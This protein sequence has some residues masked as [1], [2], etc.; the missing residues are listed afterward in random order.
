MHIESSLSS[1]GRSGEK[2]GH[3]RVSAESP[4]MRVL[5]VDD[6]AMFRREATRLCELEG[7]QTTTAGSFDELH[8]ALEGPRPDIVLMDVDLPTIPG[9]RLGTL[10][11][12]RF[13][14]PICLVSALPED[15]LRRMFESSDADAWISKPLTRDKLVG[16]VSKLVDRAKLKESMVERVRP[17]KGEA[18]ILLVED[19]HI[20]TDRIEHVLGPFGT[21]TTVIDG[22]GAISHLFDG[23]F[24][25]IVL[26][27][28]LPR[29][30]GFDVIR[31]LMMHRPDLLGATIVITGAQESSL[32]FIDASVLKAVLIK[33]FDFLELPRLVGEL[34]E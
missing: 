32:Q 27:L 6:N 16:V 24:D 20:L 8:D 4:F 19:D 26:D 5:I 10:V 17:G 23:H 11:H 12:S 22:E 1:A 9:H 33:P 13:P 21:V 34:V 25:A 18:K 2:F 3:A 14:V 15:K 29:L 30:S 7:F 31:H 28:M